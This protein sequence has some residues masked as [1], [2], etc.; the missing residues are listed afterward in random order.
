MKI[1]RR[2]FCH[3]VAALSAA[4]LLGGCS[5]QGAERAVNADGEPMFQL[6]LAHNMAED[7]VVHIQLS[8]FAQEVSEKSE[9]SIQIQIIPNGTLGSETD[10]ITQIQADGLD[11]A[12]VSAS[13]LGNFSEQFNAFSVPC[14]FD[15]Q[16]HYYNVLDSDLVEE[17][18]ESTENGGFRGLFWLDSGA[19]SF[20]TADTPIRVPSDLKGLKIRTMD[21]QMAIDMMKYFGGSATVM[22]YSDIYTGMQQGVI[23]GAENNVTALRDHGDVTQYYCFDEHTRIPDMVVISAKVWHE[24]SEHQQNIVR[25]CAHNASEEYKGRWAEFETQV[26]AAAE[27]KGVQFIRDVD[28]AAFQEAVAPIYEQLKT[29]QPDTYEIVQR[30]RALA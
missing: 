22:G 10:M 4:A 21:S 25:E 20:Y 15:S 17:I 30:I 28:K 18:Y 29:E 27:E 26:L 8:A 12:K 1:T 5:Q 3:A 13:T 7:H 14:V 11:M 23:D 6:K 16:E 9:G 19:R 2:Q 24:M